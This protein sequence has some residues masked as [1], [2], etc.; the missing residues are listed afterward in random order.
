[1]ESNGRQKVLITGGAGFLGINLIRHLMA[2]GYAL[3]SLDVEEF[4][5]PEGHKIETTKGDVRDK[6]LLDRAMEGVDFVVHT[7]AFTP[8]RTSTPR[9]SRG[10]ATSSTRPGATG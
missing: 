1:M 6:A 3:A 4:D 9:T 2:K 7:A 5:Y 10:R 8:P